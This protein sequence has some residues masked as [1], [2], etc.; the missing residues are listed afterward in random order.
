M[1][2]IYVFITLI[3]VLGLFVWGKIRHDFVALIALFV[4]VVLGLIPPEKAFLGFGHPA[5]ITVAAVLVIGSAL[6]HSGL[7]DVLGKWVSKIGNNLTLQILT[8]SLVVGVASA[9]MNNVGALAILMPEAL[10]LAKKNGYSP[11]Y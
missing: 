9:F 5:V 11:S 1:D 4:L 10:N 6:E 3:V 7:I 2:H 8:L